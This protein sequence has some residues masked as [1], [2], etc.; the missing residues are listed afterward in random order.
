MEKMAEMA[1]NQK[2]HT[3]KFSFAIP[4]LETAIFL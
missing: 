2:N 4:N 1:V 3:P